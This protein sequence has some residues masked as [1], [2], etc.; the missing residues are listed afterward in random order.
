MLP[1]DPS[2]GKLK[3]GM[4]EFGPA[5]N[6]VGVNLVA[7]EVGLHAVAVVGCASLD[8]GSLCK[9]PLAVVRSGAHK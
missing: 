6:I 8:L 3:P 5:I 2:T 4:C 7:K 1:P 9:C